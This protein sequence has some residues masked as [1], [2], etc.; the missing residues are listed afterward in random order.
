MNLKISK[1]STNFGDNMSNSPPFAEGLFEKPWNVESLWC[2]ATFHITVARLFERNSTNLKEF[3][4]SVIIFHAPTSRP[5]P[6]EAHM[7]RSR[8]R[9]QC[10]AKTSWNPIGSRCLTTPNRSLRLHWIDECVV[11]LCLDSQSVQF[12]PCAHNIKY[13][14]QDIWSTPSHK[15]KNNLHTK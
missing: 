2:T 4:H 5:R 10:N 6:A 11:K 7:D 12:S 8:R 9:P 14:P 3:P 15:K 13:P 1:F